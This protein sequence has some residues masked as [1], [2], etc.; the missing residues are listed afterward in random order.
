MASVRLES[1]KFIEIYRIFYDQ[2]VQRVQ[3]FNRYFSHLPQIIVNHHNEII[4]GSDLYID[5]I[6]KEKGDDII[7][8]L[9]IDIDEESALF[10]AFNLSNRY[11]EV[12]LFDRLNFVKKILK[13]TDVKNIYR[14]AVRLN[15]KLDRSLI[16]NI[17]LLTGSEF[18]H[19]LTEQTI[20]LQIAQK[21]CNFP[22]YDRKAVILLFLG[23]KYSRSNQLKI[24]EILEDLKFRERCT[25]E[26][27]F[28]QSGIN[29]LVIDKDN[30]IEILNNLYK[31]RFPELTK[32]EVLWKSELSKLPIPENCIVTHPENFEK[33][34]LDIRFR[35]KDLSE[36]K[37]FLKNSNNFF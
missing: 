18:Q 23:N 33:K 36:L 12:N 29:D 26:R 30:S 27:I 20:D 5:M 13:H 4:F 10:L 21:I 25:M 15:I 37:R 11:Y 8:I 9:K 34:Y 22:D 35:M 6:G 3:D 31:F 14:K 1:L 17:H 2:D 32:R 28:K 24:I 7:E 16:Q 19:I